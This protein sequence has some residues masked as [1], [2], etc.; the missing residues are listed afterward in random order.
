[1]DNIQQMHFTFIDDPMVCKV[2]NYF[3]HKKHKN[4]KFYD[5]TGWTN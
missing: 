1:M 3:L 2:Q 5:N 4:I